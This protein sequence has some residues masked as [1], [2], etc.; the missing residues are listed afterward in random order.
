MVDAQCGAGRVCFPDGCGDPGN[1]IVVE[2]TASNRSGLFAQDFVR[3]GD[4]GITSSMMFDVAGPLNVVGSVNEGHNATLNAYTDTVTVRAVGQSDLIPGVTR[5]YETSFPSLTQG[6][7]QMA[8]GMG[9]YELTA[10]ATTAPSLPPQF[11]DNVVVKAPDAGA[12]YEPPGAVF[13]FPDNP[14][15]VN[16]TMV[17]STLAGTPPV[18]QPLDILMQIQAFDPAT[19]RP[20]SQPANVQKLDG[21]FQL[22]IDPSAATLPSISLLATP[23]E[24]TALAP[25]KT[26]VQILPASGSITGL[27]LVLGDYGV[28]LPQTSGAVIGTDMNPVAGATVVVTGI[29]TGGGTFT[30]QPAMT[31]TD[32]GFSVNLLASQSDSS[33]LLTAYPPAGSSAGILQVPVGAVANGMTGQLSQQLFTC[34][35]RLSISGRLLR[36]DGQTPSAGATVVA[37]A[38]DTVDSHVMPLSTTQTLTTDDGRFQMFLDPAIYRLDFFPGEALPQKSRVVRVEASVDTDAGLIVN[39]MDFGDFALS[40]G[41]TVSGTVT[42]RGVTDAPGSGKLAPNAQVRFFRVT[43]V[44]GQASSLLI[45]QAITDDTGEF[46]VILPDHPSATA[47]YSNPSDAGSGLP[48]GG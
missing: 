28:G 36:P 37:T 44:E 46:Q 4:G 13:T 43:S 2:V 7:F 35:D 39:M 14:I 27:K 6:V 32:G 30:S 48:D 12:V 34:P 3:E 17:K 29:V 24:A 21:Q 19:Q 41:R 20:L 26:F 38:I 11:Q 45:G 16:G 8:I 18:D 31:Q 40:N 25:S 22:Y 23:R 10:T 9:S 47:L 33:L 5:I 15:Y 1:G 42:V